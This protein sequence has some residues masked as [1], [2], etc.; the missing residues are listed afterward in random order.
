MEASASPDV[1]L[2]YYDDLLKADGSNNVRRPCR[3]RRVL[4]AFQFAWKRRI[5]VLR[6]MG[7]IEKAVEE[8]NAF[9]DTVYTDIDGWL[10]LADIHSSCYQYA[11]CYSFKSSKLICSL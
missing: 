4:N 2:R 11:P 5:S 1:V 9:L 3:L 8:L 6:R 7:K 10:E